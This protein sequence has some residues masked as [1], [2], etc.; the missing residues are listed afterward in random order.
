M[1]NGDTE[2]VDVKLDPNRPGNVLS[3][4]RRDPNAVPLT[5]AKL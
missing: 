5:F 2:H 3:S 4:Y 1:A